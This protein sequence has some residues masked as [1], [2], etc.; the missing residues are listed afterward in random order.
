MEML[1]K[2][3]TMFQMTGQVEINKKGRAIIVLPF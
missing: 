3:A 1:G 2:S